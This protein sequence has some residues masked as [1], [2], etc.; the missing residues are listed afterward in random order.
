MSSLVDKFRMFRDI[1]YF[2]LEFLILCCIKTLPKAP[3]NFNFFWNDIEDVNCHNDCQ[4]WHRHRVTCVTNR[5]IM[6]STLLLITTFA[7]WHWRSHSLIIVHYL[8]LCI[9]LYIDGNSTAVITCRRDDASV[10]DISETGSIG[11]W[12]A[13]TL[14][15]CLWDKYYCRQFDNIVGYPSVVLTGPLF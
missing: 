5:D 4:I 1:K 15:N 2:C 14:K 7:R 6:T 9:R 13:N 3:C 12:H 8:E 10:Y 11:W